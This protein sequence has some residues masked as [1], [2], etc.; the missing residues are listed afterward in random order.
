[1][2]ICT[3]CGESKT[4]D[5]Y[6]WRYKGTPKQQIEARCKRCRAKINTRINQRAREAKDLVI[7]EETPSPCDACFKQTSC[8]TECASYRTWMEHGV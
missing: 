5:A 7:Y 4:L 6:G 3:A 8:K 1:M 2:K